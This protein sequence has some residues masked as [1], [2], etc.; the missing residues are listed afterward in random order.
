[1]FLVFPLNG[2]PDWRR[3][4]W[5]TL[6]LIVINCIVYFGPQRADQARAEAAADYYLRSDL[7]AREMPL[8][9]EALQR[10]TDRDSRAMARAVEAMLDDEAYAYVLPAMEHDVA[11]MSELR[12]RWQAQA[13]SAAWPTQRR[14]YETLRGERFN[15][16]W[17]FVPAERRWE[18]AFTAMF[19]HASVGHLVG[20][21][22][23]L[24]AFGYTVELALG[25]GYFL[26]FY[27]LAGLGGDALHLATHWN[28]HIGSLGASGAIAGLMAMYASL[29]GRR[30]IRFFYQLLFYFD[31]V[32]APAWILVPAWLANEVFQFLWIKGA[33]IGYMAHAGGLIVGTLL[34][35][36]YRRRYPEAAVPESP[37]QVAP[38]LFPE[39]LAQAR[40]LVEQLKLDEARAA[41]ARLCRQRPENLEALTAYAGLAHLAPASEDFHRSAALA[42]A[43]KA[44]SEDETR[45]VHE[46]FVRYLRDAQPRPRLSENQ[47]Q[48][49]GMLFVR[50]GYMADAMRIE[51]M[52]VR[53]APA[54]TGLASL[55]LAL[56]D[57]LLKQGRRSEALQLAQALQAATPGSSEAR[58]AGELLA[59]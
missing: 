28:A 18:T 24:F 32:R 19:M 8:Y 20:N 38:D 2:K 37:A 12:Q 11:F 7:P 46:T 45:F 6:L 31:H 23:F 54:A 36:L 30:R 58:L 41:Y 47:L 9:L 33:R 15:A 52:L 42:F 34:I 5:C 40:K 55:R 3:P 29:Y 26:L 14:Q 21:M 57:H 39:A 22:V 17:M 44:A 27:L 35:W 4:P 16:E 1:M 50:S 48:R 51:A 43:L 49:L 25:A 59:G 56:V 13:P 10:R 53:L